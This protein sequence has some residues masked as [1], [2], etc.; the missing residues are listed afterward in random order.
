[1]SGAIKKGRI[2]VCGCFGGRGFNLLQEWVVRARSLGVPTYLV[3]ELYPV[4]ARSNPD[5]IRNASYKAIHDSSVVGVMFVILTSETLQLPPS[6]DRTGGLGVERGIVLDMELQQKKRVGLLFEDI[7]DIE[8]E[9]I[10][11]LLRPGKRE[12]VFWAESP[13]DLEDLFIK[14]VNLALNLLEAHIQI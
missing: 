11:S 2:L 8:M 7:G 1:M 4:V 9:R 14:F 3:T 5:E 6:A 12:L 10:S 13:G